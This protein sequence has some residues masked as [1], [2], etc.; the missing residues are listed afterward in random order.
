MAIFGLKGLRDSMLVR[1]RVLGEPAEGK[2][3]PPLRAGGFIQPL[4]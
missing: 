3:R 4:D 1:I 2:L